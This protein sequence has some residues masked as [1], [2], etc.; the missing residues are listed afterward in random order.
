MSAIARYYLHAGIPV[1]GYDRYRSPLCVQLEEEG[2]EIIY[3]EDTEWLDQKIKSG[4]EIIYTPALPDSH[5]LI[6]F[7]RESGAPMRKRSEELGKLSQQ[8]MCLAIGGTHGKTTTTSMLSVILS[9]AGRNITA[10]LGGI[11]ANF[12]SNFYRAQKEEGPSI[13]VVEADEYDRSF[14]RLSPNHA[15]VTSTDS[16]HLDIYGAREEVLNAFKAFAGLVKDGKVFTAS[17]AIEGEHYSAL[18]STSIRA[19]D[20]EWLEEGTSFTYVQGDNYW[21]D[22]YLPLP[23]V[24]NLENAVGAISVA[25]EVGL[26]QKEIRSGLQAFRGIKRRFERVYSDDHLTVYDDYA[27]HPT[28]IESVISSVR[29]MYRTAPIYVVFQPHLY[30]RTRD[31]A[32]EFAAALDKAD[33]VVLNPI[34]P[35]REEPIIGVSSASIGDEMKLMVEYAD[36]DNWK[37]WLG[38]V[39]DGVLLILGAGDIDHVVEPL[40]EHLKTERK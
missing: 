21:K 40:V 37:E 31:F 9:N 39:K 33:R 5:K 35:A 1:L 13:V 4:A 3:Q 17:D 16:D 7:A 26:T 8:G 10:F 38:E 20:I 23:G 25:R 14:L 22:F 28:E 29:K 34:Y 27:H 12:N 30:S 32:Q 19:T 18:G 36:R 6:Q 11:S 15:I 2:A 24:H